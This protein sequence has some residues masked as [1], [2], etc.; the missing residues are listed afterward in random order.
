[1]GNP[2][3]VDLKSKEDLVDCRAVLAAAGL[4]SWPS[5]PLAEEAGAYLCCSACK[6]AVALSN[7]SCPVRRG[8]VLLDAVPKLRLAALLLAPVTPA[9]SD[10]EVWVW[11]V[12]VA[13][14]ECPRLGRPFALGLLR[15]AAEWP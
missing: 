3:T 6:A 2:E 5:V 15:V 13:A 14:T 8:T 7:D 9:A 11:D 10:P 4:L 12:L 1:M